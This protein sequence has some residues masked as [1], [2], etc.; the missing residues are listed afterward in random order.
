[1]N[2]SRDADPA[3]QR[4]RRQQVEQVA[5]EQPVLLDRDAL[6]EVRERHPPQDRGQQRA[7][8]DRLVPPPAPPLLG[9]LAAELERDPADDQ[10]D[11]DQE[12][13]QVEAREHRRV[14]QRERGEHRAAGGEHPHLVAVPDG[15]IVLIITRRSVSSWASTLERIPTPKSKPSSTK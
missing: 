5:D 1:V 7:V 6:D 12:Q 14:P 13:R 10:R 15:P 2:I 3:E 9:A 11:Q 8:E 4:V